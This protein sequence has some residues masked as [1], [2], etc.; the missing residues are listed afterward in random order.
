MKFASIPLSGITA[1]R[2]AEGFGE[3]HFDGAVL[4]LSSERLIALFNV[5]AAKAAANQSAILEF[6]VSDVDAVF[7]RVAGNDYA[8]GEPLLAAEGPGRQPRQHFLPP[9]ELTCRYRSARRSHPAGRLKR[10]RR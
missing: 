6:E 3:I 5:G 2:P 10:T 9:R 4:A 8:V 1:N 7:D